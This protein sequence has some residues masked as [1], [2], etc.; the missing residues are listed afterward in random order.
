MSEE[1]RQPAGDWYCPQ[2]GYLSNCRVTYSETCDTCHIPVV[3]HAADDASVTNYIDQKVTD[4][5]D[6]GDCFIACILTVLGLPYDDRGD[7]L[8]EEIRR[9]VQGRQRWTTFLE[10]FALGQGTL[11]RVD[12]VPEEVPADALTIAGGPSPRGC[13][14]GHAVVM[15]GIGPEV[16]HDPHPSRA[17][18][19]GPPEEWWWFEPIDRKATS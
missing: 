7:T 19:A 3:W 11:L 18:L 9:L 6:K 1:S 13:K 10:G 4:P 16:L 8:R 2:C 15:R 17:G 5:A 14:P 12:T